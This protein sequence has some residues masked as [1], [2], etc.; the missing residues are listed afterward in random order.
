MRRVGNPLARNVSTAKFVRLVRI[1]DR[2][3]QSDGP[4]GIIP[5]TSLRGFTGYKVAGSTNGRPWSVTLFGGN[6]YLTHIHGLEDSKFHTPLHV[7][8]HLRA[9]LTPR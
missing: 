8:N 2:H 1:L 6:F 5:I 9:H 3:L 7:L 4:T